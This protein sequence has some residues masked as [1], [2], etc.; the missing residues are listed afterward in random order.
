MKKGLSLILLACILC[1]NLVPVF[2]TEIEVPEYY[3]YEY[4]PTDSP[5]TFVYGTEENSIVENNSRSGVL[6]YGYVTSTS[7]VLVYTSTDKTTSIGFVGYRERVYVLYVAGSMYYIEF[8]NI[9]TLDHGF[10][11]ANKISIPSYNWERPIIQGN[12]SQDFGTNG[13]TGIDVAVGEGTTIYAVGNVS[14]ESRISTA[15][16]DGV[17]KFINYGNH[18]KCQ[19]GNYTI[20]YAHLSSFAQGTAGTYTS[21]REE[22]TGSN[23]N[24]QSVEIWNP[25]KGDPIGAS[26]DTG[27]STGP[28]LHFEVYKTSSPSI[29][30]DPFQ[31][32][33][34]PNTGY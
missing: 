3:G 32:V 30:Y 1:T 34:F 27:W 11:D 20:V 19:I 5:F 10:V 23:P 7:D 8:K 2:A 14:H 33:V 31:F 26:G 21:H 13:H 22:Y 17:R 28:H 16:I 24:N 25:S 18:I 9:N 15:V 6:K 29:K 12:I 4:S